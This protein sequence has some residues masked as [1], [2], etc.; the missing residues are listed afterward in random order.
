[1]FVSAFI[2]CI[3]AGGG[4]ESTMQSAFGGCGTTECDPGKLHSTS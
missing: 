3:T 2:W 4:V 1:M